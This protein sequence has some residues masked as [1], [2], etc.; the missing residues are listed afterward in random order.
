MAVTLLPSTAWALPPTDPRNGV[1]LPSLQ[2]DKAAQLDEEKAEQLDGW[3]GAPLEPP[4]E[5]NPVDVAPPAGGTAAVPLTGAGDALVQAG[6]LPVSIGK[7]SPTEADPNPPA[8]TGTW[9][10]EIEPRATTEDVEVDGAVITVTPP[11]GGSAPVDVELDYGG[12]EDLYGTEWASRLEL[13]QLPQCFLETPDLEECST[14]TEVPSA[15]DPAAETVRATID[16]ATAPTQGLSTQAGGGPVVLAATDSASG[17]GG[18]YKATTLSPTGSWTAGGSGG[19]FSWTYPLAVPSPPAGPAPSIGFSYSSQAVDGKTSVANGQASWVGDGWDYH[20][21]FIER[22]YRTCSEDRKTIDGKVPN[23]T[24]SADKKKS[25]LC[26]SGPNVVMSLGGSTTELVVEGEGGTE[27]W[28]PAK[29]DGAKIERRTETALANGDN[30]G[31]HWVVTARDG[32]QYWFG[33]NDVDG[34]GSRALTNSVFT[35]PVFGNHAD[36]PCHKTA[37]ADSFCTQ[38]WRWNLDYVEDVHGNAMVIDW[39]KETNHYAKNEKF[40]SKVSY[41]RGGHPSQISYGL[42]VGDISGAP[43]GKVVFS[44]GERCVREGSTDCS[45]TEFESKNYEDKQPWWDTPST[46]HCKATAKNCYVSSPTFWSRLRLTAVTTYAQRTPGSTSLSLVDKWNLQ[47]S[48]PKQRT[49]THPPLWLETIT[50]TGFGTT[51]NEDGQQ[52]SAALPSVSFLP[53]IVDMPNRVATSATDATPDFDR[54][55]VE[56]IRTETGGEIYVAYSAPCPVGTSHPKP[57]E[58][59]TRCFPVHWSPDPDLEKPPTEW[60]NKYVVDQVVEK[61]R[62][63]QQPDLVTSYTYEGDAAWGKD[64][65]EFSKPEL[66]TYSQWRGYAS[67]LTKRGATTSG[68]TDSTEQSQTRTRYFRGMSGDG[69]RAKST[70][71]D[72]T[73]ADLA[74]DLYA[75]QGRTAE[76]LT[77]TKAGGTVVART[78]SR[79]WSK[80]TASRPRVGLPPLEAYRTGTA[81]TDAVETVSTG[82]RTVRTVSTFDAVYGLPLTSETLTLTPKADGGHTTG[83]ESCTT[84]SYVHNTTK[85]LIGLPQRVRT[86]VG[87]CTQAPTAGGDKVISDARTSYDALNAFGTAPVKG[88]PYQVDT[89]DGDGAGWITS[90]RTTYDAL[91][92]LTKVIDAADEPTST[93]YSPAT[94]T[95]FTTTVTNAAG[96]A[97]TSLV[98]PARGT[99][100]EVTDANNR[101]ITSSY[102][103]LGRVTGVWTPS[104]KQGTDQAIATFKYQIADNKPP[105]VTT[106]TL[107]DNGTYEDSVAIYDGLLRPRQTQAEAMGGGRI[108]TDSLYNSSGSVRQTNNGYLAEGE[109]VAEIFYPKTDFEVPNSTETAY[110]GLGRPTKTTTLYEGSSEHSTTTKYGGDWTLTRTGMSGDGLSVGKGGRSVRAWTD[111][112]GRTELIQHATAAGLTSWNSTRYAYDA[113]GNH[114]KVTDTDSN[115][116]TYTYDARGRLTASTDP[117][118][119]SASFGYNALDQKVW[120]KDSYERTQYTEYDELGRTTALREGSA[121]GPLVAS[122]T[123]DILPGAKGQPVAST[124]FNDGKPYTS[125]VTG[126]DTEYRP[127]GTRITVPDTAATKGLAGTYAY[128]HTY[129]PT[130]KLQ[131]TTLPAAPGGLAAEKLITRYNGEGAPVTTSGLSWYTADTKYS[132]FGEVLRAASGEAPRRVWTTNVFNANTGFVDRTIADRETAPYRLS[133]LYY[134]YDTGGNVTDITDVQPSGA[135][136]RQ[137]FAYDNMGQL[138]HG[139]TGATGGCPTSTGDQGAGPALAEVTAGPDGDGYW[140]SYEFDAIGNRTKMVDHDL[141]NPALDD[142]YTYS[143]GTTVTGNGT[144]PPTKTQPHALSKVD[145]V[146]R[147]AGSTVN[148]QSTYSYD[149]TGN[150]TTRTIGGDTQK[151]TWDQR[152]KLT[153]VDTDGDAQSDVSYLY[154]ADGN[155]LIENNATGRTLYLGEAEITVN[156]AGTAVDAQRYYSHPGAPTTVRSTAGKTTGHKLTVLLTDHHNTGTTAVELSGAM[157]V[158]RRKFDPYGNPRGTEP[159]N[160]PGRRTFLGTGVDDPATG[161][162]H[163]GAREYDPTTGRFISV[164]PIIDI[165]DPLQMNGYTYSN[166]NPVTFSDPSGLKSDECGTLYKCGGNQVIT[167]DTTEYQDVGTVAKHYSTTASLA[168][169]YAWQR[170]GYSPMAKAVRVTNWVNPYYDRNWG[171]NLLA[172]MGRSVAATVEFAAPGLP[173]ADLYDILVAKM[174]VDTK[175]RSYEG[176]EGFVDALSMIAPGG[177]AVKGGASLAKG[178]GKGAAKGCSGNSFVSGTEVLLADG[179]SKPIEALETG[180]LV[181]ATD[182]ETGETRIETVTAEITGEGD[183]NLVRITLDLGTETGSESSVITATDGHPFWVP[184]LGEWIDATDLTPGQWLQTSAG[185]YIQ[186]TA[187]KRWTQ[188]A[189]VHNLTVSNL[190]TYYVLAGETPVLVHNSNCQFWSRTDYNGQRIYQR[191]DLVNPDYFSPAD[192]YGRSNLKRMQQGLAPMGPDGKPLNLHHMLQTQDGPIAEVTHSMHFG[193]YNQLHW[194]AGT[195]IPSGIDRDAFNAWKSQYWKDRAAGFGG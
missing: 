64:T 71:K 121:S 124:R 75:Y 161:L 142:E 155:R 186:I 145:S 114:T 18:T 107:R 38:A 94:G 1:A 184:E 148:S 76:A 77:Y 89:V 74:E 122:W 195:K 136:D 129:T 40:K 146:V 21:G 30:D 90:A 149:L 22:R 73:G 5:Y 67:V 117:D 135:N 69:G 133:N 152:N 19:G 162:T 62:V 41:V 132:P 39:K 115:E 34:G 156:T 180:D 188:Q 183:K 174:G 43:A 143:Y 139:W 72:S 179:T 91:G 125:E 119:G 82:D 87:D 181:L 29:D 192:K 194:K 45:D 134:G 58:N 147:E 131:T 167:T 14:A 42:R 112:L 56:T 96:H 23:N 102:D 128:S 78:V 140:Q 185:T 32:T 59:T 17:A 101:K 25:D 166:G 173:A 37:Y 157:T 50:R 48:F 172:G 85:H 26:W 13:V 193:N 113:R 100:L 109:P 104:R 27:T 60:F 111:V 35:A 6:D 61:D 144:Q 95:A 177:A 123:F 120:S 49:D 53:N 84:T 16:P 63:A 15:N 99:P 79:P 182:S 80:S 92:R 103:E 97:T 36:E 169:I 70:V 88:L 130:G 160:W 108:I 150:T 154:D 116:W 12:F 159:T 55:R 190:H 176:G 44:V 31:E 138:V 175:S 66:R 9:D 106:S 137:C 20:P 164:D 187:I 81:R 7:A 2:R 46:L 51:L 171:W 68:A 127:T 126:Y 110:D 168:D 151:L 10:V 4:A 86:T 47:Q 98:D 189:T 11:A 3:S 141:T 33:R 153:S 163:I 170:Q 28:T 57:E 83:N 178:A 24:G 158:S 191:D 65:D 93:T 8:P 118:M 52:E 54:L 165:T 105:V